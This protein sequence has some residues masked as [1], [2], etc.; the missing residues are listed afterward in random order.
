MVEMLYSELVNLY[1]KIASTN[2]RLEKEAILSDFLIKIKK[3]GKSEWIYLLK[4]KVLPDHDDREFGISTQLTIKAISFAFGINTEKIIDLFKKTGD[5]GETAE[6]FANKKK[7]TALFSSKLTVKKVFSNLKKILEIE[8]KGSIEKKVE[9]IAEILGIAS[10]KETKYIIRTLLGELRIGIADGI[11]KDS[12]ALAFFPREK[13]EMSEKIAQAYDLSN[14]FALVMEAASKGKKELEKI[15]I[16]PGIPLNPMLPIKVSNI[17]EAFEICGK[18]AAIEHK[19]DGF[20]MLIHKKDGKIWLFTRRLENV[21][22]Q[23][24]DIIETVKT[25]I[26][27]K[28]FILDS[29]VVGFNEKTKKYE[30]FEAISQRIK[31]KHQIEKLIKELPVEIN[32]FD[33]LYFNEKS[34]LSEP[35]IERRKL[36]EKTIIN[37]KWKIRISE[38]IITD[39]EKTAKNF[40][41]RVL[42]EGEEGIIIKNLRAPY[43]QGRYVG[44][45]VKLKPTLADL[46]LVIVGAEYGTG[47][48]GGWLTSF[49]LGCKD[50]NGEILEVGKVSSGLKELETEKG[51]T[52]EEMT[53]I[54]KPLII[55][56]K[57]NIVYTKPKV[58]V[59][60]TYQNIQQS[61]SYSSGYALRFP[62]ITAYRPDRNLNDVASIQDIVS[63]FKR[64]QKSN[65]SK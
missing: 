34:L 29:E 36:L 24:P 58:I 6:E 44:Y 17:S 61:P 64:M 55:K 18:P 37:E 62:R 51:T 53:E 56:E 33:I 16:T 15:D 30:P 5:L 7:Q 22:K 65:N 25:N 50:E 35:F 4:G 23:F 48:R 47:K 42:S 43:R 39:D 41:E 11:I 19:Y 38:Q 46:D 32:V 13:N 21:T 40:Y 59:S 1:E 63:E 31:R 60:V 2:K 9:L 28:N 45:M 10:P 49:I 3:E 54:L 14:D 20:R 12:I 26:K 8:G 52:F 57:D 27:A